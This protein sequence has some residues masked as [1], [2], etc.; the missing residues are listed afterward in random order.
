MVNLPVELLIFAIGFPN[1]E[2]LPA[3]TL[4]I[5]NIPGVQ[6]ISISKA[7]TGVTPLSIITTKDP[8]PCGSTEMVAGE[9]ETV[10]APFEAFFWVSL[11]SIKPDCNSVRLNGVED[12][13]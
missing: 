10:A 1:S 9:M 7:P 2:E 12:E 3:V 11:D 8:V 4:L 5:V 6:E 13:N